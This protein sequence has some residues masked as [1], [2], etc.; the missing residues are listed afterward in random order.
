MDSDAHA[1]GHDEP[2]LS[3]LPDRHG[4]CRLKWDLKSAAKKKVGR[5]VYE[6]GLGAGDIITE[7]FIVVGEAP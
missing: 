1:W 7:F 2:G 4:V 3:R 6:L 5:G